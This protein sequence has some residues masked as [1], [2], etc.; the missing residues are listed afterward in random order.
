MCDWGQQVYGCGN[1]IADRASGNFFICED[2]ENVRLCL[3]SV[4]ETTCEC[5]QREEGDGVF[6]EIVGNAWYRVRSPDG[7]A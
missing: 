1:C 3:G 7:L 6:H 4:N 5:E 2:D